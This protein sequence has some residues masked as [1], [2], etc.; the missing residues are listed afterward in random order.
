MVFL[1]VPNSDIE[2]ECTLRSKRLVEEFKSGYIMAM[3]ENDRVDSVVG[4][5]WVQRS[6]WKCQSPRSMGANKLLVSSSRRRRSRKLYVFRCLRLR[7]GFVS[8]NL[9][10]GSDTVCVTY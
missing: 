2:I 10:P 9:A 7:L 4:C 6:A 1:F 3:F 8:L 5:G